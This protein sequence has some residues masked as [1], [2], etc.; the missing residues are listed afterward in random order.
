MQTYTLYFG[1][2]TEKL[3]LP[4][5]YIGD[6]E[7]S[8]DAYLLPSYRQFW[9]HGMFPVCR[10]Q[11]NMLWTWRLRQAVGI[12]TGWSHT[13]SIHIFFSFIHKFASG[14]LNSTRNSLLM[15]DVNS[16]CTEK[17]NFQDRYSAVI[18]CTAIYDQL[19]GGTVDRCN[20]R[21]VSEHELQGLLEA[22]SLATQTRI[23]FQ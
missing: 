5:R 16:Y 12:A 13:S 22:T 23:Y 1:S 4:L 18:W 17:L 6:K 8:M 3:L 19:N 14:R 9:E 15:S 2:A 11:L 20:L 7:S 21:G 10:C